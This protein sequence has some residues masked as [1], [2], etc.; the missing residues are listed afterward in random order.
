[1]FELRNGRSRLFWQ[2]VLAQIDSR[3]VLI[4]RGRPNLLSRCKETIL[5]FGKLRFPAIYK[6]RIIQLVSYA[7]NLVVMAGT[8]QS[9]LLLQVMVRAMLDTQTISIILSG[10]WE[11]NTCF[12]KCFCWL[13]GDWR[14]SLL[15]LF[16]AL[17]QDFL[18]KL[19]LNFET[20]QSETV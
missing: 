1:M 17:Y 16:A 13:V 8:R 19:I 18:N 6:R 7:V 4:G 2:H 5:S 12:S 3:L 15:T 9:S 14:G 20:A 10:D 11:V